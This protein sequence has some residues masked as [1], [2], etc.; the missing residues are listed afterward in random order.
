MPPKQR[1]HELV[2]RLPDS[3]TE[4]A[5]RVLAALAADPVTLSLLTAPPDDEPYTEED[6]RRDEEA[7]AALERGESIAH[8]DVLKEFGLQ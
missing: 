3:Q 5:L 7:M 4:T 8:E 6:R 2:D 1:L